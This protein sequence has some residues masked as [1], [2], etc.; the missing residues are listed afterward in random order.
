MNKFKKLFPA[1]CLLLVA[2]TLMGTSTFAWF[3]MNKTVTATG[4]EIKAK[5]NTVFLQIKGDNDGGYSQTGT[6]VMTD[7][8]VFPVSHKDTSGIQDATKPVTLTKDNIETV[9]TGTPWWYAYSDDANDSTKVDATAVALKDTDKFTDYVAHKTFDVNITSNSGLA[10]ATNLVVSKMTIDNDGKISDGVRVIIK[11][12]DG[13]VEF[14]ATDAD[15][16]ATV[17]A[18]KIP[19]DTDSTKVEVYIYIEGED[20]STKTVDAEKLF[21]S[22]EFELSCTAAEAN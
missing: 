9:G 12:V 4:M 8:A 22:I 16:D 3:S 11:G 1:T 15:G 2:C 10:N 17:I 19:K 21:G 5:S 14:T 6:T 7:T 13:F 18:N 20:A